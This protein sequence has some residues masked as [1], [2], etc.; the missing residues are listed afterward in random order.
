M[1]KTIQMQLH[2]K[3]TIEIQRII[4]EAYERAKEILTENRE[5]LDLI[6]KTLL[7]VETFDAEQIKHLNRYMVH[8]LNGRMRL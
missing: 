7:E 4:K 8:C 5:I 2:M 3:L 1:N 6:A